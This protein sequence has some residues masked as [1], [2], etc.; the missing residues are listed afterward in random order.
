MKTF[1]FSG[2]LQQNWV[3]ETSFIK[4]LSDHEFV[5]CSTWSVTL[6]FQLKDVIHPQTFGFNVLYNT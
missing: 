6:S 4:F 3:R 5:G 1:H 2:K